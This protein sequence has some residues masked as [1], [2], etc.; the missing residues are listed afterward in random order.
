MDEPR[1]CIR[2]QWDRFEK[3][4]EARDR[5]ARTPCVYVQADRDGLAV[6]VGKASMGLVARYRG[7]TGYALDAAMHGS[8]NRFYVAA[9]EADLCDAVEATL[10]YEHRLQLEHN[11]QG[12]R[13]APKRALELV[14]EGNKPVF[15]RAPGT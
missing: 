14:H 11:N 7:G 3:F 12:K 10:I 5:F 1:Q 2:L 4:T 13:R 9:I 6:R 15:Q 8:E